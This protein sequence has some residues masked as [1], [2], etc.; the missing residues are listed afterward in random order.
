MSGSI[1]CCLADSALYDVNMFGPDEYFLSPD[2]EQPDNIK[3][4]R[5]KAGTTNIE[6]ILL[7][8]P[9][10]PRYPTH[11]VIKT[12]A[13]GRN[14]VRG[15]SGMGCPSLVSVADTHHLHRPI[16]TVQKYLLSENFSLISFEN[17]RHHMKWF[18]HTG[19]SDLCW[20]PNLFLATDRL[21]PLAPEL[22]Q[23]EVSFV[24]SLG[25]FHPF[26]IHIINFLKDRLPY[27]KFGSAPKRV[28]HRIYNQSLINLNISLN[29]DLNWRFFEIIASGGFLLTDRLCPDSGINLLFDEGVHYEAF[30]TKEE[31]LDKILYYKNNPLKACSIAQL[32]FDHYWKYFSPVT[33][34]KEAMKRLFGGHGTSIFDFADK[35]KDVTL[36][37]T[38]RAYQAVQEIYRNSPQMSIYYAAKIADTGFLELMSDYPRINVQ[39]LDFCIPFND[40]HHDCSH[41]F[42]VNSIEQLTIYRN[43]IEQIKPKYIIFLY[44]NYLN[45]DLLN[46]IGCGYYFFDKKMDCLALS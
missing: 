13:L 14:F 4:F 29:G 12:D 7:E 19:Q 45:L 17:D 44:S 8:Y 41:V 24:G 39:S 23:H 34:R 35:H 3:T 43:Q 21:D 15:L 9:Q 27:L 33:L 22:K 46:E 38:L 28:A 18:G 6:D 25:N 1:L 32:A 16:E 40:S 2:V 36:K 42:L 5:I 20:L 31:L 26:R 37:D 10:L 30:G 11:V